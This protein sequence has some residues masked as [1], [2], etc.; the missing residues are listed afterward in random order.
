MGVL[1]IE[2]Q[3]L[4]GAMGEKRNPEALLLPA[5]ISVLWMLLSLASGKGRGERR[6]A[7]GGG[8][9]NPN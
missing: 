7:E 6:L 1:V 3:L 8:W 4:P 5:G 2:A 9:L